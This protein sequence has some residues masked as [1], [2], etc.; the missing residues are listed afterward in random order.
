M[1]M[2]LSIGGRGW[3][4]D[5]DD[6]EDDWER[7]HGDTMMLALHLMIDRHFMIRIIS[8]STVSLPWLGSLVNFPPICTK[9]CLIVLDN[10]W[11]SWM[12]LYSS[13]VDDYRLVMELI[14]LSKA[15]DVLSWRWT[16][17]VAVFFVFIFFASSISLLFSATCLHCANLTAV[18]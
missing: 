8:L 9:T 2:G 17:L 11:I 4:D 5:D 10:F 12:N 1:M 14:P 13:V 7:W 6:D 18:R 16:F 15:S 3:H